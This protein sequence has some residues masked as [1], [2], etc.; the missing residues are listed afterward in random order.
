MNMRN[1]RALAQAW[2]VTPA[3]LWDRC[4]NLLRKGKS[5]IGAEPRD[6][7]QPQES[8]MVTMTSDRTTEVKPPIWQR[9]CER[10]YSLISDLAWQKHL[11]DT[12]S[13]HYLIVLQSAEQ[14]KT[15]LCFSSVLRQSNASVARRGGGKKTVLVVAVSSSGLMTNLEIIAVF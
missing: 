7:L 2:L 5:G 1:D 8:G 4:K 12:D 15:Y 13:H 3:D 10:L 14:V 11:F 9:P 6:D